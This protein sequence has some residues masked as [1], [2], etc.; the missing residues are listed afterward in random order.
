MA[1]LG[2]IVLAAGQR[3]AAPFAARDAAEVARNVAADLQA[4]SIYNLNFK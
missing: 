4:H 1:D 2:A 3:L